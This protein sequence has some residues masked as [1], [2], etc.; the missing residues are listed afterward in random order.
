MKMENSRVDLLLI[1]HYDYFKAVIEA[2]ENSIWSFLV[3][4]L[5]WELK[6][7]QN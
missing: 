5:E 3:T 2:S 4:F 7:S 6:Y 1:C